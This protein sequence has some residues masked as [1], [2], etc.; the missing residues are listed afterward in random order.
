MWSV[1]FGV[2]YMRFKYSLSS[3]KKND[4]ASVGS[5]ESV[6][7]GT[8]NSDIKTA[9]LT[10]HFILYGL[11]IKHFNFVLCRITLSLDTGN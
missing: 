9:I 6:E 1:S 10:D 11:S 3:E 5:L 7:C 8:T 4:R 2:E